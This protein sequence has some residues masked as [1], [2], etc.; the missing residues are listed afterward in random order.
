MRVFLLI[1]LINV[2]IVV[3]SAAIAAE[4]SAT[5]SRV[6]TS[7]DVRYTEAVLE[8]VSRLVSEGF[9]AG[10]VHSLMVEVDAMK[11]ETPQAW[12]YQVVYKGRARE[13]QIRAL[14]DELGMIDLDFATDP[15]L[16]AQIRTVVDAYLS[17]RN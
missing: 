8:R 15:E 16:A 1:M 7:F 14:V 4:P 17:R 10:Q 11:A 5:V 2:S 12:K 9:K 6:T 13:L 3:D